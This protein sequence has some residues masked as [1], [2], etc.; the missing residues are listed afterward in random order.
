[1]ISF[2]CLRQPYK[3]RQSPPAA[4]YANGVIRIFLANI[5]IFDIQVPDLGL[6]TVGCEAA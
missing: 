6:T 5:E 2:A 1:M 3:Y 4:N